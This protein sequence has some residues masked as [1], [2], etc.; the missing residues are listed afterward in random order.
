MF[1]CSSSMEVK[2]STICLLDDEA[3][4]C[5][6][7]AEDADAGSAGTGGVGSAFD[8]DVASGGWLPRSVAALFALYSNLFFSN[9]LS[10][11]YS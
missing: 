6:V 5:E 4:G 10:S 9:S 3:E 8:L 2:K 7:D 11:R 1:G